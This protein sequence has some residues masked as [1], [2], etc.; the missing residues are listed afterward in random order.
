MIFR[1]YDLEKDRA[2]VQRIWREIKWI[3]SDE[4]DQAEAMDYFLAE[5]RAL[6]AE[7]KGQ[8]E[9]MVTSAPGTMRHL[10]Q[11]L[12]LGVVASVTTSL[13]ARKLGLA[14]RLTAQLV[15]QDA[16]NGA[17]LSALGM[18]DQGFYSRLGFGTGPYEHKIQFNPAHISISNKAGVPERITED[19]YHDVHSAL[20]KRWRNHGAVQV[21]PLGIT[22]SELI[23]TEESCGFGYRNN[24]GELTHFIWGELKDENGP[25]KITVL[26]Y[27][28]REQLLELLALIRNMGDQI[29]MV[30]LVEPAHIQL[31]DIIYKPFRYQGISEGGEYRQE[32][33]AEAYWQIRVNDLEACL[34]KTKLPWQRS[35]RLNLVLDDPISQFIN[36]DQ[37][38]NG[39]GGNYILTLGE[40]CSAIT[41]ID[42]ALPTLHASVGG[43]TRLWLACASANA[44]ATSGDLSAEQ[45]LLDEL[46][47]II[48]LPTPRTGWDF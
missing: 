9:C 10:Q 40:N 35:L 2:A 20:M 47:I 21:L 16:E 4:E 18:F 43:F 46:D 42:K 33:R 48:S 13:I 15:A 32:N 27:Q 12:N 7:V 14:S 36:E 34:T 41:G 25:F 30:R 11:D 37:K 44:L 45:S 26:A 24:E 6:V 39:V 28:N 1:P 38:W 17:A 22:R 31:Q 23:W 3:D 5:S 19:Q 8:A 29:Y